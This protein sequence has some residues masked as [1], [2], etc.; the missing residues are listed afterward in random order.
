[1]R[2]RPRICLHTQAVLCPR[3]LTCLLSCPGAEKQQGNEWAR[4]SE[5]EHLALAKLRD[6]AESD[7]C[8]P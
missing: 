2:V 3:L 7:C 6:Q 4:V 1:M 8:A 5:G